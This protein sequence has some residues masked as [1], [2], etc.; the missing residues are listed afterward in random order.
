MLERVRRVG[1]AGSRGSRTA[2]ADRTLRELD[3]PRTATSHTGGE[4][5]IAEAAETVSEPGNGVVTDFGGKK[6]SPTAGRGEDVACLVMCM[7]NSGMFSAW[8]LGCV[9]LGCL[10]CGG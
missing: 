9:F 2:V 5:G 4:A 7:E 8:S 6:R 1:T 10:V 3:R